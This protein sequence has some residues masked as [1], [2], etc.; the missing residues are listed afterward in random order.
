[1]SKQ[2]RYALLAALV[3]HLQKSGSWCGETHIQKAVYLAQELLHVPLEYNFRLYKH[4][5]YS[6]DLTDELASMR[7]DDALELR[8]QE[9]PYG[10]CLAPTKR[11]ERAMAEHSALVQE[12]DSAFAFIAQWFGDKHVKELERL[13]TAYLVT[14]EMPEGSPQ[15]DRAERLHDLKPHISIEFAINAIRESDQMIETASAYQ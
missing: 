14:C 10:P 5:P 2:E 7:A 1:M 3:T 13:A 11:G 6:F 15:R 9:Y 8:P 12:H 4:G